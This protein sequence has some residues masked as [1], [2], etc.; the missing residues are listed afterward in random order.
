MQAPSEPLVFAHRGGIGPWRENTL[1]AFA[2][3]VRDGADG[4]ELDVRRAADGS[5]AIVHDAAL[6]NVGAVH[7]L[8]RE[9][10]PSWVPT[11]SEALNACR[12]LMVNVEIK[13]NPGD[14]SHD[15]SELIARQ[16][17]AEL[18]DEALALRSAVV[19]RRIV[20]SFSPATLRAVGEAL[21]ESAPPAG[22]DIDVG[23]D[24][25]LLVH[26]LVEART[27]LQLALDL[28]CS[29]LHPHESQV[30]AGLVTAAHE[31]GLQVSAWT[32]N[33][34]SRVR[35]MKEAGVDSIVTDDVAGTSRELGRP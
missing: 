4:V 25:G 12:D 30:T 23:F 6:P 10:L 18:R 16:V 19:P 33:G 8:R 27:L 34:S 5:L 32:V 15:P 28:G 31:A 35:L 7:T 13:N 1:E 24:V 29:A 2:G 9:D 17:V 21:V 20:S 11:L 26:P 3:A 22:E 14:P